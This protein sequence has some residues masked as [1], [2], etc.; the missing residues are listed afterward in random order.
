M[1][2]QAFYFSPSH[3]PKRIGEMDIFLIRPNR[4]HQDYDIAMA[5]VG[6]YLWFERQ[7][8][9]IYRL[10]GFF[11]TLPPKEE[12]LIILFDSAGLFLADNTRKADFSFQRQLLDET[13]SEPV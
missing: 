4:S 8:G 3:E 7:S 10:K 1:K 11:K 9:D 12:K 2:S 6:G 5:V 13:K